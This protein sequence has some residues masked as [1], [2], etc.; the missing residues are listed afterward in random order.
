VLRAYAQLLESDS[1]RLALAT[2]WLAFTGGW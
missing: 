1:P 2:K